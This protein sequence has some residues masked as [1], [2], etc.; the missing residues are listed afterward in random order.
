MVLRGDFGLFTQD[1]S[2]PNQTNLTY[3]FDMIGTNGDIIHFNAKKKVNPS[4]AFSPVKTWQ[5]TSTLYVT[6]T[7]PDA[8]LVG[9]GI[10]YI[11]MRDFLDEMMTLRASGKSNSAR[12][13]SMLQ[14][15]TYFTKSVSHAFFALCNTLQWPSI[16]YVADIS[17]SDPNETHEVIASDGVKTQMHMWEPAPQAEPGKKVLNILWIPGAGVDHQI[18]ALPT[19]SKNAIGYFT[20]AGYRCWC[21]THRIGKTPVAEQGYTT[22]DARLDIQAALAI[23]R[24]K[25][26]SREKV[27]V[28]AHCAGSVALG[29][30]LLDGTI[31]ASWILGIT[32]S[33]V[34]LHPEFARVNY[35]KAYFPLP[36]TKIYSKI[37]GP[38]YDTVS[39][40][41]DSWLQRTLTQLLRFY[42]MG[43][44]SELCNSV[45]CHRASLVFGKLWSH[46]NLN[47][48]THAQLH[49]FLGG[50]SMASLRHLMRMGTAG[51]VLDNAG[52]DSLLTDANLERLRGIPIFLF[53]GVENTVY[54][55]EATL[56]SYTALRTRFG[57][58]G[59]ER[60]EFV[61]R[62]HLDCWMGAAEAGKG[63]VYEIVR[64]K[65]ERVIALGQ[66]GLTGGLWS[67]GKAKGKEYETME[68]GV[69]ID[70]ASDIAV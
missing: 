8:S 49:R 4:V 44:R 61:G 28:I 16:T 19:I 9:K 39:T 52:K 69:K 2:A 38:F 34:F 70:G 42:P 29:I 59:Y 15:L 66:N 35:I 54:S 60:V 62:G 32:A 36:L 12:F 43:S 11:E 41:N 55:P 68:S 30:G 7:R 14:F 3:D 26:P 50:T 10:L 25:G 58:I 24:N 20:A 23:I 31:D 51:R 47:E 65:M 63:G 40:Q 22:Y 33:N 6:L 67:A 46:R 13:R 57:E 37:A 17:T 48:M 21:I 18:F 27:Y 53:S 45:V 64:K 5:A 1:A 56:T